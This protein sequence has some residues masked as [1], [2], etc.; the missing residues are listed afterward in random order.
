VAY[1]MMPGKILKVSILADHDE[2]CGYDRRTLPLPLVAILMNIA[3]S[4]D[5][6]RVG[7]ELE[8]TIVNRSQEFALRTANPSWKWRHGNST[9]FVKIAG[10]IA[11]I[12][13]NRW[14]N[15]LL[16]LRP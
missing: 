16:H 6:I 14:A 4:V 11:C 2:A 15:K 3:C 5:S 7:L 8:Y 13:R 1:I 12:L 9:V 10:E